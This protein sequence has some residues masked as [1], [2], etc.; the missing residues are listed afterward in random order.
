LKSG[1]AAEKSAVLTLLGVAQPSTS[2]ANVGAGVGGNL[3]A[4]A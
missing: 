2:L 4:S 3:N 1:A